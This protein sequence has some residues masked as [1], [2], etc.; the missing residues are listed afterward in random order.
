MFFSKSNLWYRKRQSLHIY[1]Y[2]IITYSSGW[3]SVLLLRHRNLKE[4]CSCSLTLTFWTYFRYLLQSQYGPVGILK[5]L[6][7]DYWCNR[8]LVKAVIEGCSSILYSS[9]K[10]DLQVFCLVG[11]GT[12]KCTMFPDHYLSILFIKFLVTRESPFQTGKP[13]HCLGSVIW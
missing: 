5:E 7:Q 11:I 1:I 13:S 2:T 9:I 4:S 6:Q 12:R 10:Y 3:S 8:V